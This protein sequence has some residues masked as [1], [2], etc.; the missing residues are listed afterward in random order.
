MQEPFPSWLKYD[1]ISTLN[2]TYYCTQMIS[3]LVFYVR[4]I[5]FI[6]SEV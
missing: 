6:M 4:D 1:P 5:I 2:Y 3:K